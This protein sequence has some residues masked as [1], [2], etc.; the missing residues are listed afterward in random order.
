VIVEPLDDFICVI[1]ECSDIT[2]GFV[3]I[4]QNEVDLV[5]TLDAVFLRI[6]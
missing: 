2:V 5:Q 4:A 3:I 6:K 1:N